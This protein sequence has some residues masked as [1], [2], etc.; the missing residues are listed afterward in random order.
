M[1]AVYDIGPVVTGDD[2]ADEAGYSRTGHKTLMIYHD[3]SLAGCHRKHDID[4]KSKQSVCATETCTP[5]SF[6]RADGLSRVFMWAY[7]YAFDASS[8]QRFEGEIRLARR[9]AEGELRAR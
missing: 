2:D 4:R 7:A 1:S 9:S 5:E 6:A 8:P 3:G